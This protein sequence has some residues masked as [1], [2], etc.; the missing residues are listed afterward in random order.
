MENLVNQYTNTPNKGLLTDVDSYLVSKEFYTYARNANLNTHQG[1]LSFLTNEPSNEH[2]VDLPY[3]CI[4]FVKLIG[5]RFA[6]FLTDNFN[7]EI[8][9]FDSNNCT[10]TKVVNSPCLNFNTS[11][12]V[13]ASSKENFDCSESLYWTD[14]NNPRRTLNLANIPYTFT[15]GDDA[16]QTKKFTNQLDCN[17]I[18]ITPQLTVPKITV[19]LGTGGQLSNGSYQVAVAYSS[20]NQVLSDYYSITIP[21]DIWSHFNLGQ[22]INVNISNL[23]REFNQY[24]LVVIY[25]QKQVS[26][27]K[28]IGFYSTANSFVQIDNIDRPEYTT[29]PFEEIT[30]RKPKYYRADDIVNNDQ[31]LLWSGVTTRPELNYQQQAMNIVPK[32]V[33]YQESIDYYVNGGSNV[34]YCRRERYAFGVQWL[35]D[36]GEWSSAFHIPGRKSTPKDLSQATGADVYEA[37]SGTLTNPIKYFQVY[38]TSK[39]GVVVGASGNVIQG[40]TLEGE[41]GYWES[42]ET[43]PDNII[44]FGDDACKPIRHPQFP[45]ECNAPR[46]VKGGSFI[47][48]LGVKFENI[49]HPKDSSGNYISNIVGYRIVR[50]SR[51][52]NRSVAAKGMFSN[53]RSYKESIDQGGDNQE[54]LYPNHPYND[55][56]QDSF[57]SSTQ[58]KYSSGEG[59][60]TPLTDVKTDQFNFYSPHTLFSNVALGQEVLFETEEIADVSGFFENVFNHPRDK[61]LSNSVFWIAVAVGAIDGVLS[62]FGKRCVTGIKDGVTN[63]LSVTPTPSDVTISAIGMQFVQQCEGL[64]NGLTF[65]QILQLP[66][67]EAVAKAALKILQTAASAGMAVYFAFNTS[68]QLIADILSFMTYQKYALQYNSHGQ[69]TNYACAPQDNT[70]RQLTYYQYLYDGINTVNNV[71]FNNFKRENSVYL[72][73]NSS[74]AN[75]VNVDTSRKTISEANICETPFS[76][77]KT[78]ASMFYG[79]IKNIIGDQYGQID[80]VVYQDTGFIDQNLT[81]TAAIGSADLFYTSDTVFGGDTY[82]NRFAFNRHHQ[83]FRQNIANTN[84]P[85]GTEFDYSKYRNVG[86]PRFWLNSE[87]YDMS[88]TVVVGDSP[89]KLPTNKYN[90][91][92]VSSVGSLTN[93]NLSNVNGYFYLFNNGVIDFFVESDYN[94]DYRDYNGTFQNFYS[95]TQTSLTDLF[96]S[97]R[98]DTPEQFVYD[99][100]L[101]KQL[102]ENSILQQRV[103]YDPT[104]DVTCFSY[105]KN[106]VAYSLP[107]SLDLKSD[108]W[109]IYLTNNF[110]DFPLSDFGAITGMHSVDNQQILF[111]F[112]KS[113]PY[114]TIGRDEL[115]TTSGLKVVIGDA[116][117]FARE[118]RPLLYTDYW[119]GNSQSRWAFINTQFGS[120]YTSQRQGRIFNW[121]GQME[122]VSR[123]GMHWWFKNYLPSFLLNTFPDFKDS[124]N[125]VV[126][127]GLTSGWDNTDEKYYLSKR[128]YAVKDFAIGTLLYDNVK[129]QFTYGGNKIKL[130]DPIYFDDASWTIS[131][132]PK[133]QLF[134]SWHDWQP[135]WIIQ[136]ETHFYTIKFNQIWTH[137]NRCD[138]FCNFYNI[139]Y[140][141]EIEYLINNGGNVEILKNIEY[142]LEAGIYYDDCRYF[143]QILDD[144]FDTLTVHNLEQSSGPLALKLRQRNNINDI[145]NYPNLTPEGWL[146]SYS[147]VE[148]KTRINEF[149]DLTK[150]RGEYTKNN[151]PLWTISS[152]GYVRTV[153]DAAINLGKNPFERKRFRNTWHKI[154]LSKSKSG[155]RKY[156]FKIGNAPETQSPR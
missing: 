45:G 24:Q 53:V 3:T 11:H 81:N 126:G 78:I 94:L 119:Y 120:L 93:L 124:D 103:D 32:W 2:C 150:D 113:A 70:R 99:K 118:P 97:D 110:Y 16:C 23:D 116:G 8:G 42:T 25:T 121:K 84:F 50:S 10:Y 76:S 14:G 90:L 36:T 138:S 66:A 96:R 68:N 61:V 154:Y 129:N 141:W 136:G 77:F 28:I 89:G 48:L 5:G 102:I 115:Q 27:A 108:N 41:M 38:D 49:E 88:E 62:V 92:C 33:L 22:A 1:N 125:P 155:N 57:I 65:T 123:N 56:G 106:R 153:T 127:V 35:F 39:K 104:T 37:T 15:L 59:N 13:K 147:K 139:D 114:I 130:G 18:L 69:F 98:I 67:A 26:T 151:F 100:S 30:T 31:F 43:Y 145:L 137:N 40:P 146:V 34:G 75:P 74:I 135:D 51:D 109:L 60:F 6:M 79:M 44:Q 72:Q 152:N 85:D 73:L 71:K 47:N 29:I 101:S 64:V 87:K 86:Y 142:I 131:Y 148:Q 133:D 52:G 46:Y 12:L 54:I 17:K 134:V 58:T 140:P 95:R 9:I 82:V 143:H 80:S 20:N 111:T 156:I 91:D 128:D 105:Y 122:E 4:G 107:A 144:N 117:L 149:F 21:Q 83:F 7:S 55:L 112:D 19:S 132:S 63:I